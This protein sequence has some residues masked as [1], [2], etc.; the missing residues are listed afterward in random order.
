MEAS[1]LLEVVAKEQLGLSGMLEI[2]DG[3]LMGLC[4][5]SRLERAQIA[6]LSGPRVLFSG[7]EPILAGFE[8]SDHDQPRASM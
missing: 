4:S 7:V 8:F 6:T 5:R 1:G 2:L 3:S